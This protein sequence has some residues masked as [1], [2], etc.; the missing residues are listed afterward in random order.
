MAYLSMPSPDLFREAIRGEVAWW[1]TAEA[2]LGGQ[3]IR[4]GL[5]PTGGG[6]TDTSRP[7]VRRTANVQLA[8]GHE[9]YEA[10]SPAGT[11]LTV[12][13]HVRYTN[14]TVVDIPMGVFVVD[15][16]RISEGD[17]SVS[18]TAP[19]KWSL[20][21]RAQ[22][23]GPAASTPGLTVTQQI[24]DL[25]QGALGVTE[26]V[27]VTATS[28]A[29][30]APLTWEKDRAKAIIDLAK[31]IG[32]WVYFDR[33]GV[34][35]VVDLPTTSNLAADWSI[36]VPAS[37][38]REQSRTDTFNVVVISSSAAGGEM[39]EPLWVWDEVANSPTYAGP[40][41]KDRP[42]LAGP[43]GVVPFFFDTPLPLTA[44][45]A[46]S[47]AR[48]VLAQR[49]GL[50]TQVS[51]GAAP[52][53]AIDAFDAID[54]LPPGWRTVTVGVR[55]AVQ[56]SED[57][58]GLGAFG[59]SPFGGTGSASVRTP[60]LGRVST[61]TVERHLVDTV[62]HP[63]VVGPAQQIDGRSTAIDYLEA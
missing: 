42:E 8:G 46:E 10:L 36:G 2:T 21:Q 40:N 56:T 25:I 52:N 20:I 53:H 28:E 35:H 33:L 38:D 44:A 4:T 29:L 43:F 49:T 63:L 26:P 11:R 37:L 54:V 60:V 24:V 7:G 39:F 47:V 32:A 16:E 14:R 57:G 9:L 59:T 58:F 6:V 1:T 5:R 13:T 34:A 61:R 62:T 50:A 27:V 3:A 41:P 31:G 48:T 22:F 18:I 30:V 55:D 45:E 51:L 19:D 23:I 12:T 17:G 15:S